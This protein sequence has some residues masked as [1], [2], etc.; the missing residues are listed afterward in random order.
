M[1]LTVMIESYDCSLI[2]KNSYTVFLLCNNI[3]NFCNIFMTWFRFVT[4][5]KCLDYDNVS[6]KQAVMLI[7]LTSIQIRI[8]GIFFVNNCVICFFLLVC[9]ISCRTFFIIIFVYFIKPGRALVKK[10]LVY[11]PGK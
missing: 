3:F 9:C 10:K 8:S 2:Q 7:C 5:N 11:H 6:H 1:I 4:L